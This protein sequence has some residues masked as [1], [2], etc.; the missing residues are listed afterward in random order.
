MQCEEIKLQFKR[1]KGQ[2]GGIEKMLDDNREVADVLQQI[3]AVRAALS[4]LAVEIL[5]DESQECL[6]K[7]SKDKK[8]DKFEELVTM[9]FKLS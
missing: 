6:G 7:G 1:I 8:L 2:I 5:K 9:F 3:A 4:K